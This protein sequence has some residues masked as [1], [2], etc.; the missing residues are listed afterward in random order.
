MGKSSRSKWRDRRVGP[1]VAVNRNL[2]KPWPKGAGVPVLGGDR[3]VRAPE[4]VP[5]RCALCLEGRE[6]QLSHTMPKWAYKWMKEGQGVVREGRSPSVDSPVSTLMQDGHKHYLLCQDCE[7]H[8][9]IGEDYLRRLCVETPTALEA[10]GLH[11][12]RTA[13]REW[14]LAAGDPAPLWRAICGILLKEHYAPSTRVRLPSAVLAQRLRAAAR[15]DAYASFPGVWAAKWMSGGLRPRPYMNENPRAF[16]SVEA[17]QHQGGAVTAK[18]GI[19]GVD[20]Y[21][22]IAGDYFRGAD[23]LE[24]RPWTIE[25]A[26]VRNRASWFNDWMRHPMSVRDPW[27]QVP[28]TASCPCGL[29]RPFGDCCQDS[30]CAPW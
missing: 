16:T 29:G 25:V 12:R 28:S 11:Y 9:G 7:L 6:L 13:P 24:S 17:K 8:L 15:D 4:V 19:G 22:I 14:R 23:I 20:V 18:I 10:I 3:R 21:F 27:S 2:E 1:F 30:W 26:D 5:G